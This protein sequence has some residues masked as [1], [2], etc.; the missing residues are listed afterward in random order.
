MLYN[1]RD[2]ILNTNRGKIDVDIFC[3]EKKRELESVNDEK[4]LSELE[5][6]INKF[7]LKNHTK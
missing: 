7:V 6:E 3:K 1:F 2:D 5:K 4:G